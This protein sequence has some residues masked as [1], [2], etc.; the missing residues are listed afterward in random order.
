MSLPHK[1]EARNL[2]G[3]PATFHSLALP[4][5]PQSKGNPHPESCVHKFFAFLFVSFIKPIYNLQKY[6]AI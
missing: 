2:H 4:W 3:P 5:L 6:T 1:T